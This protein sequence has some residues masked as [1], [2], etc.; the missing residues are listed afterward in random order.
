MTEHNAE[1]VADLE[2]EMFEAWAAYQDADEARRK[3]LRRYN[4]LC[5]EVLIAK[6]QAKRAEHSDGTVSAPEPCPQCGGRGQVYYPGDH[7]VDCELCTAQSDGSES[8]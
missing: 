8:V 4:R 1:S 6:M 7:I 2:Q 3:A 5:D